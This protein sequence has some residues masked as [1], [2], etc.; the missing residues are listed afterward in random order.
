MKH[1][2][3]ILLLCSGNSLHAQLNED[4]SDGNY[5]ANPVWTGSNNATDFAVVDGKLRSNSNIP[6]AAFFLSTEST[7]AINAQW[8]FWVN[9]QIS[10]SGSNYADIYVISDKADLKSTLINGFFIRIGNTDDEISLYR[11]SGTTSSSTKIIDGLNGSVGSSNNTIRIRLK[12]DSAGKFT[13]EREVVASNTSFVLEGTA[14]DVAH[15][16]STH[17]GI[18]IQQSTTSFFLKHFFDNIKIA[19]I[20]TDTTPPIVSEVSAIGTNTLAIT[21]SEE[22]DTLSTKIAS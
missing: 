6:N 5:T 19:P 10:T 21:F 2:L 16:T 11:R 14:N 9:L 22:M 15:P 1:L 8:E 7:L 13:L 18:S 3:I 17:F 20:I 12:R 4:F